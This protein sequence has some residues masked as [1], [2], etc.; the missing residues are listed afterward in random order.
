MH[1]TLGRA[2]SIRIIVDNA[3][4]FTHVTNRALARDYAL[5][6][7]SIAVPFI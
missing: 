5:D 1:I 6:K 7:I 3:G 2:Y 4:V